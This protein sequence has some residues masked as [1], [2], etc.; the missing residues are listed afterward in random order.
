VLDWLGD[1][2]A[3]ANFE[4]EELSDLGTLRTLGY[5]FNWSPLKQINFIASVTHEDGA[6]TV[7]QLGGPLVVTPNVRTY[8]FTRREVI[9]ITRVFGGNPDLRADDRHVFR[10]ALNARPFPKADFNLL[11]EYTKTRID[12]PIA[13]FPIAT[14]EI[15]AAFPERFTRDAD[16]RLLRIDSRPL[17]FTRSDKE[18]LRS[19]F[20][21]TRTLGA[22]P[23]GMQ[24]A[25]VRFI[26]GG[27]GNLRSALPPGARIVRPEPGSAASKRVENMTSRLIFGFYHTWHWQDE[28]IVREGVPVLDLLNGSAIGGRGG[29]PR[30]ELELEAGAFK[31]G[32]GARVTVDWQ[33]GTNVRGVPAGSGGNAADLRFSAYSTV[34]INLFA[35][36]ADRFGGAKAPD[37]LKGTRASIGISN[38]LNSRPQ[39]E[40][41][42]GSTPFNY[43]PAFL[44]PLGRFVSFSLRKVF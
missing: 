43:Q 42:T 32:I 24:N 11:F 41:E 14:P 33:S 31:A 4:I 1:L 18:Q 36:L 8:D 23:P 29:R 19:G 25:N 20:N 13:A 10:L 27:E 37:W 40:D 44:E 30:H 35:N 34:N 9:D 15:E 28:I 2:S 5:G 22:M 6:P 38:L 7:E 3:N 17:N 12:D 26:G 21:Y 16:G 39:V